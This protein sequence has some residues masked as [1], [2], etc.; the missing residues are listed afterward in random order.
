MLV[1]QCRI[2]RY[3]EDIP[4]ATESA[5]G[6]GSENDWWLKPSLYYWKR[7]VREQIV[8]GAAESVVEPA[9]AVAA[10]AE[11]ADV[12]ASDS[13]AFQAPSQTSCSF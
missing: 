5:P 3:K 9:A 6:D 7:N 2:K 10:A 8:Q 11:V 13:A 12:D 4:D 1:H